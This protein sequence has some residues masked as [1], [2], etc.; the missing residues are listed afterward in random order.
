MAMRWILL[1][2]ILP[3]QALAECEPWQSGFLQE[4]MFH[5]A[6]IE[7]EADSPPPITCPLG[8]CLLIY[9][10]GG[11]GLYI[12]DRDGDEWGIRPLLG[13]DETKCSRETGECWC[14]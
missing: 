5:E 6:R 8:L 13:G 11:L 12:L 2:L 9:P 7:G 3:V 1:L 4:L 10:A 14:D